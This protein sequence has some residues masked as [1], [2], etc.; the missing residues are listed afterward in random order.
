VWQLGFTN[1]AQFTVERAE[2]PGA[3][4]A[5]GAVTRDPLGRLAYDDHAVTAGAR[6]G[7]RLAI[8][9]D[10]TSW[11]A[12]EVWIVVPA[13]TAFSIDAVRPNPATRAPSVWFSLPA[14][15]PARL[16]LLDTAG[17]IVATRALDGLA[18]G[19]H[20][21][22]FD[23]APMPGVYFLRLVQGAERRTTRVVFDR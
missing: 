19:R 2:R 16:E 18:A 13:V 11:N 7:Y 22:A 8:Q 5:L 20:V 21:L 10:G 3:W 12:G 6:Y 17:R 1:V 9:Q 14:P 15:Q 23:V 4:H